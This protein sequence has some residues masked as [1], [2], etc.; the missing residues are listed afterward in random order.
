MAWQ[1]SKWVSE[2][3]FMAKDVLVYWS[4]HLNLVDKVFAICYKKTQVQR[5]SGYPLEGYGF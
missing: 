1:L 5:L 4:Y 2:Y 3:P